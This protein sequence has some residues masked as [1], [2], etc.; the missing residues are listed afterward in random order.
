MATAEQMQEALQQLQAQI[1]ALETQLQIESARAQTAEQER[2]ALIQT[3][4]TT[5]QERAGGMFETKGISQTFTLKGGA[6]QDFG[7]WTHKVR[8][9][10]V[11]RFGDQSLGAPTWASRQRKI[12]VKGCEPSQRDRLRPWIDV[13]GEGAH[14][15]DQIDEIDE[16][17][18]K[19]A[20]TLCLLQPTQPTGGSSETQAKATAWKPGD[21]CTASTTPRR[22]RDVWRSRNRFR[23]HRVVSELRIWELHWRIGSRRNVSTRCSPTGTDGP[24]RHQTTALWRPWSG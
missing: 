16:F 13:F 10:M 21:D 18:G 7:E 14:E 5:R 1:V 11:A 22:P 6:E 9:F 15:E 20:H 24:A 17:V 2:S 8:T 4:E 12:G 19:S 3:L 23:T